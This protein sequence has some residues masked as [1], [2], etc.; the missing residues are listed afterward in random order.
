MTKR[1]F[2]TTAALSMMLAS[3]PAMAHDNDD[4]EE[5]DYVGC[6]F[7]ST[8]I[9]A[10][11]YYAG[12]ASGAHA[13][14]VGMSAALALGIKYNSDGLCNHVTEETVEAFENAMNN[15]GIQIMWHNYHDPSM[16]WCLSIRQYD[17]IPY[18]EP[19]D[20]SSFDQ[21]LFVQQSWEA[22]RGTAERLLAGGLG[23][24]AFVSPLS[25]ADALQTGF[26]TSG[27]RDSPALLQNSFGGL[28]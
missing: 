19:D 2:L 15:L 12:T 7:L 25:L 8:G 9:G 13:W 21:Q 4:E 23:N 1:I 11:V 28:E 14:S 10:A 5:S 20:S 27:F 17:C 18:I 6:E 22:A 16:N 26:E 3:V 24:S